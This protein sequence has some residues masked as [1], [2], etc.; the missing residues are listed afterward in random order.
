MI[1][2][3]LWLIFVSLNPTQY[4]RSVSN[5]WSEHNFSKWS[6]AT[7]YRKGFS[8]F[9]R[10]TAKNKTTQSTSFKGLPSRKQPAPT[11]QSYVRTTDGVLFS[12]QAPCVCS[13]SGFLR[14]LA[15]SV[16]RTLI[17]AVSHYYKMPNRKCVYI[18]DSLLTTI[19]SPQ[20]AS[21][22]MCRQHI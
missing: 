1:L 5:Y 18:A 9:G 12:G 7:K 19:S 20:L 14:L 4:Q 6:I 13:F 10:C 2:F 3:K 11:S 17:T 15:Q 16:L 21:N 22:Q 8:P